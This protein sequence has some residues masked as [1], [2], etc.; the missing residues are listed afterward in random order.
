MSTK[1][2]TVI[3][4]NIIHCLKGFQCQLIQDG[5]IIVRDRKVTFDFH[6]LLK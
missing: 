2:T 1:N 5:Y 4:G 6:T 3:I